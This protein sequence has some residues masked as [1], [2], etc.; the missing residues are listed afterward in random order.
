M[1]RSTAD[2][3][4]GIGITAPTYK[5]HVGSINKGLRVEGPP[6]G[7]LNPVAVSLGGYGDFGIDAPGVPEGRFVVK[8]TSGFVGIGTATPDALLSVNGGADKPGGGSWATF[9]DR[10]L[11]T[12]D[13]E[14][15]LGVD[16]IVKLNPVRYR[17]KLDNGMEFRIT[18]NTLGW[19]RRKFR[20]SSQKQ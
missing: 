20:R 18:K 17:Y 4:V 8:D 14:F 9:S 16:E 2:T 6:A 7:T 10:R 15:T 5:L 13:G 3:L 12:L 11:K 1:N 19:L